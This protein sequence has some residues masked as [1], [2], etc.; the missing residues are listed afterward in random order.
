MPLYWLAKTVDGAPRYD[1][2][3]VIVPRDSDRPW[4]SCYCPD[5]GVAGEIDLRALDRHRDTA[6]E[7]LIPQLSCSVAGRIRRSRTTWSIYAMLRAAIAGPGFDG[8]PDDLIELDPPRRER[9]RR[10]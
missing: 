3:G 1:D 7:S 5:C 6:V 2:V 10:R 9:C 4:L 8:P